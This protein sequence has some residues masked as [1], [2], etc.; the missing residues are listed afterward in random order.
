[1]GEHNLFRAQGPYRT[2]RVL[3]PLEESVLDGAADG[4]TPS[5]SQQRSLRL[6]RGNSLKCLFSKAAELPNANLPSSCGLSTPGVGVC[7]SSHQCKQESGCQPLSCFPRGLDSLRWVP[8]SA[9]TKARFSCFNY[10]SIQSINAKMS[11]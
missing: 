6:D 10:F 3:C 1:M 11:C 5:L 7:Q 8:F 4:P 9:G 2:E